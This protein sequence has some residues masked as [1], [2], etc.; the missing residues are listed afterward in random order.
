ILVHVLVGAAHRGRDRDRLRDAG[1]RR[2]RRRGTALGGTP[3]DSLLA[4]VGLLFP[5][6]R[7]RPAGGRR[8]APPVGSVRGPRRGASRGG[9]GGGGG[10]GGGGGGGGGRGRDFFLHRLQS[11]LPRLRVV[12]AKRELET[13]P[14]VFGSRPRHRR[15]RQRLDV[16]LLEVDPP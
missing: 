15:V 11:P 9:R 3:P 8:H 14:G 5:G 6:F 7:R 4:L 2:R 12:D 16:Q 1:P 13:P 10:A